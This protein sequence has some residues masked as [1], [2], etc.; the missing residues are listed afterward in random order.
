MSTSLH[1]HGTRR[2]TAS[3]NSSLGRLVS[4]TTADLQKL[5]RQE[6]ALAKAE[7]RQE[8]K[9]A[10]KAA[11]LFGGA[12]F[13]GYMTVVIGSLAAMFGL[14]HVVD[15]AWAA[16][17]IAALWGV[18]AAI[19]AALGRQ[20]MRHVS[21]P[22]R[23]VETLKEDAHL[24]RRSASHAKAIAAEPISSEPPALPVPHTEHGHR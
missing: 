13:A 7:I 19:M 6:V 2:T 8:A 10:G 17:I 5:M 18:T 3:G 11:G 24:M 14:A 4:D 15:I 1:G 22:H 16:L 23:T 20:R 21:P 9:K 12:G